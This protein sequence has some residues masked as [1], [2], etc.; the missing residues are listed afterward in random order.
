M[1][2][3]IDLFASGPLYKSMK[4]SGAELTDLVW[5]W[6]NKSVRFDTHC[7]ACDEGATWLQ[8]NTTDI[9]QSIGIQLEQRPDNLRPYL[10]QG[11]QSLLR[12]MEFQCARNPN[13]RLFM[14]VNLHAIE[15]VAHRKDPRTPVE[16]A[17]L[18]KF[19]QLPS[20]ADLAVGELN[21]FR[22]FIDSKDLVELNRAIGLAAHGVGIGSFVYLRRIF[23]RL[24]SEAAN[25]AREAGS[26]GLETFETL[27]MEDKLQSVK[28]FVPSWMVENRKLYSILSLGL[29]ELTDQ[30]CLDAFPAVKLATI[31]LLEQHAEQARREQRAKEAAVQLT[32]IQSAITP[33]E[34]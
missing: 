6:Q 2:K 13:H 23:E 7:S 3:I 18:T 15:Y 20:L 26:P 4:V 19:G 31:A 1:S 29:H 25:R 30:T 32:K 8:P 22:K 24:V 5:T 11:L 27:R 16:S 28:G 14:G 34:A 12:R 33:K 17:S 21:E 9:M 10:V